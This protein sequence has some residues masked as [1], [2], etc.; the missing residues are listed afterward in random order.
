MSHT[1]W[2]LVAG[3]IGLL[4]ALTLISAMLA[5]RAFASYRRSL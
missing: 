1:D 5:T 2:G 4:A 3:R